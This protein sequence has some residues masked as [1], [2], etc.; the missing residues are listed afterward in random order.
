MKRQS[1]ELFVISAMANS[2][3]QVYRVKGQEGGKNEINISRLRFLYFTGF[4]CGIGSSGGGK[5]L[6]TF[7]CR[8]PLLQEA[9]IVAQVEGQIRTY[10]ADL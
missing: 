4:F 9:R 8:L 2:Y 3:I 6:E 10:A 7:L 5:A 1:P